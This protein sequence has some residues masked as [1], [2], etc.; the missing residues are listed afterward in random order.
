M[1]HIGIPIAALTTGILLLSPSTGGAEPYYHWVQTEDRIDRPLGDLVGDPIRGRAL[2]ADGHKGN[3]LACHALPI[4]E[5]AFHGSVGPPLTGVGTR[6]S[7]GQLRLRVVDQP[8]LNP[9]TIMPPFYR[10]F[11]QL[12]QVSWEFEHKT[13]L[14]A[15]D[16][17]D[18][19]AYLSTLKVEAQR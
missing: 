12:H 18:I 14:S 5:Q 6:L 1:R 19:V 4:P 16:V 7:P 15:Q 2:V 13:F 11:A 17:E 10:P 3:C 8:R 9:N